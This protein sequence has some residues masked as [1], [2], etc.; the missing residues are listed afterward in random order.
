MRKAAIFGIIILTLSLVFSSL[1]YAAETSGQPTAVK[2][3][4]MEWTQGGLININT[5]SKDQLMRLPGIGDFTAQNI[6]EG[7]PYSNKEQLRLKSIV[8]AETYDRI[9]DRIVVE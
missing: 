4:G 1:I 2:G 8:P 3:Q 6:I 9:K 7:R 5:A